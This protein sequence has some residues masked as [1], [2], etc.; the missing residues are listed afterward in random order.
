M[1]LTPVACAHQRI[2]SA[3]ISVNVA[4]YN[5]WTPM[6]P[7]NNVTSPSTR[8]A[9][10]LAIPNQPIS[11]EEKVVDKGWRSLPELMD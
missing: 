8:L 10:R 2:N 1:K 7:W 6:S 3:T 9:Y 5:A 4:L 11:G